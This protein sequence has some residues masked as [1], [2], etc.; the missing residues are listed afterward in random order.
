MSEPARVRAVPL[1][2]RVDDPD[3]QGTVVMID[4]RVVALSAVGMAVLDALVEGG[5]LFPDL[6]SAVVE[7]LGDA[8]TGVDPSEVVSDAVIGLAT[9]GLLVTGP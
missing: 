4:Q 5:L 9:A 3:G 2:D 8:P 6:V 1:R 7:R